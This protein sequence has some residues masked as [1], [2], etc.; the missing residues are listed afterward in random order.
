MPMTAE[1]PTLHLIDHPLIAHKLTQ[2]RDKQRP[3]IGFRGLLREITLLMT[4]ETLRNLPMTTTSI[5]TPVAPMNAPV[6]SGTPPTIVPILRAGLGMSEP[7]MELIPT[8]SV[9]HIGVYRDHTTKKPVEYL[10]K[11]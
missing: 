6:L 10:V 5:H 11:L 1:F 3:S 4:Y 7:L 8:S 2:M 9:G